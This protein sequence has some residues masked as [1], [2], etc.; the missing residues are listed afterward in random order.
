MASE[1]G[2]CCC[3]HNDEGQHRDQS[4]E[5]VQAPQNLKVIDAAG[6]C[7]GAAHDDETSRSEERAVRST[8]VGRSS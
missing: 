6:C 5:G 1:P 8:E 3:N 4:V 7:G 2:G